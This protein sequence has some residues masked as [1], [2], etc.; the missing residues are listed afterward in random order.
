MRQMGRARRARRAFYIPPNKPISP[1]EYNRF[2]I[3][4]CKPRLTRLMRL[5]RPGE[6]GGQGLVAGDAKARRDGGGVGGLERNPMEIPNE[7]NEDE[8]ENDCLQGGEVERQY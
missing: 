8:R 4:K 7:N 6:F 1:Y 2:P 3:I 5:M